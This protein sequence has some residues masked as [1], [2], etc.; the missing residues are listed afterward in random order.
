MRKAAIFFAI[1]SFFVVSAISIETIH[2]LKL[3]MYYVNEYKSLGIALE[4]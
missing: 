3:N 4:K 1:I 2:E